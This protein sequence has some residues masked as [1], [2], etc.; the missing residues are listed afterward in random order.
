VI[1]ADIESFYE[2]NLIAR[3]YFKLWLNT[4]RKHSSSNTEWQ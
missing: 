2:R 4:E 1:F 3:Y